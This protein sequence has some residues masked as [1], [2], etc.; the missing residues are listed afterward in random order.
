MEL[1]ISISH[2]KMKF[3]KNY[4]YLPLLEH[5]K[6]R[7]IVHDTKS[8][9]H[10]FAPFATYESDECMF[11]SNENDPDQIEGVCLNSC[12]LHSHYIPTS[13]KPD[14]IALDDSMS[15]FYWKNL[16]K[17]FFLNVFQNQPLVLVMHLRLSILLQTWMR[18]KLRHMEPSIPSK[19]Y[20]TINCHQEIVAH[21]HA[22]I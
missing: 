2:P 5:C 6:F 9:A 20:Q 1:V 21:T 12:F 10:R 18:I 14:Q 11:Y 8:D 3:R 16:L 13:K 22:F 7:A 19:N 15:N 17:F 4:I